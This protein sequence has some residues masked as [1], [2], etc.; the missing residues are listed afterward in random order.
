MQCADKEYIDSLT[1]REVVSAI[2]G[3]DEYI[4]R[5]YL[6]GKCYP[7]FHARYEKYYTDCETC[8]EFINQMYLYLMT[9]HEDNPSR[10]HLSSFKFGC[11]LTLWLKIVAENY[12]RQLYKKKLETIELEGGDSF[13][14]ESE[15]PN[16]ESI[17]KT[18]VKVVLDLMP[19]VRYRNLIRYR[20]VE[21][22]TNEETAELLGMS[23]DNYYNKHRL[24]KEQLRTILRKEGLL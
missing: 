10:C 20:Y 16:D 22:K 13:Y 5:L 7:L 19:N 15:S 4:T 3:R 11:Q 6:Y 12:C 18:D 2:L 14:T 24:A 21:E 17:N 1:D 9:P 8:V 23:M